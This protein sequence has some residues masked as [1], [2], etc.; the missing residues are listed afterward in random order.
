MKVYNSDKIRNV[1]ILGHSGCG[2][3]NL[4][5]AIMFN[6]KLSNKITKPNEAI[7][8]TYTMGLIPIEHNG[9]KYNFLDTPGYFDFH[10]EVV[11]AMAASNGAVIVIDGTNNLEVGTEKALEMTDDNT[12]RIIFINKIDNEKADY[13]NVIDQLTERYGKNVIPFNIP[14]YQDQKLI[15]ILDILEDKVK[16]ESNLQDQIASIKDNLFELIAETDDD[17]LDKYFSGEEFTS[18]DIHKGI[19]NA[20]S[21]CDIIPI[22]CGSTTNNVGTDA[23]LDMVGKYIPSSTNED[24]NKFKGLVF[25]TIVDPF[26]GKISYIKVLQGELV[27]DSEIFNTNKSKKEKANHIYT[28]RN[29]EQIELEK[30]V[31]GDIIV[32]TK[33]N[34]TQTGDTLS[35]DI[36]DEPI[37]NMMFP[38][39]QIY[40]AI[41][42]KNKGDEEKIGSG[43]HKLVE[44]DPTIQWYRDT[45]TKQTLV[46]GQGELHIN[47]IKNRLKDKF[48]VDVTLGDIKVPYRET[49]KAKADVQGKH[50]KQSGGHGQY[51]DVKIIFEPG[52]EH[53][54]FEEKIFGGSVP[55]QYI[56]AVEKGLRESLES[57]ALAGFPVTNIKATLYDGSYHDV[58]SSEMAFK[59]A[60]SAA[61]KKGI[62]MAKPVLLEPIMNLKIVVPEEYMGDVI[63]DVNKRRGRILGMEPDEKGK[64]VI[65]AQAPQAETFRYAIDLRSMTQGRGYFEM[66]FERY[67]EIPSQ[68]ASKIVEEAKQKINK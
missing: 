55:K 27:K 62:E 12:P 63:G 31:A 39:P 32:L 37:L 58:D 16:L 4:V 2:K 66:E 9:Y 53:F 28:V 64:Q 22:I 59:M 42:P 50:K 20:I 65:Y 45:E 6:N 30:A 14:I 13:N 56:P 67:E 18:E 19:S 60:A 46:G 26:V 41:E 11:S 43:L 44:E 10:G 47:S 33:L 61:F 15:D 3:T 51:G 35:T 1:V 54:I 5:E 68:L 34:E 21:N 8:M 17:L 36:N 23:L 48:G 7:N 24:N 40:F 52:E 49:I 38:K 25:K 29:K 57:G